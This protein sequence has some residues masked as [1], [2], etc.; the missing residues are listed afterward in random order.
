[1]TH[2]SVR[3]ISTGDALDLVLLTVIAGYR[4]IVELKRPDMPVLY[5][6]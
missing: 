4:D 3:E 2:D 1:V 5:Y 6:D